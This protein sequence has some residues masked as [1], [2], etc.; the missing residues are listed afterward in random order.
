MISIICYFVFLCCI[1]PT[2]AQTL[3]SSRE[4]SQIARTEEGY[5]QLLKTGETYFKSQKTEKAV[6]CFLKASESYPDRYEVLTPQILSEVLLYVCL[7]LYL[8]LGLALPH[9]YPHPLVDDV[10]ARRPRLLHAAGAPQ[11]RQGPPA[12]LR[13]RVPQ[14]E[15]RVRTD[16][17]RGADPH[18]PGQPCGA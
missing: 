7:L 6:T 15:R 8:R 17:V 13:H 10:D 5:L 1:Q 4:C 3:S 9:S 16:R 12:R 2:S 14:A 18:R 11:A